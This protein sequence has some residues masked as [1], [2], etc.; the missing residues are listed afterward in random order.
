[1]LLKLHSFKHSELLVKT[2]NFT[3]MADPTES[4]GLSNMQKMIQGIP[5]NPYDPEI[6][7][8]RKRKYRLIREFNASS[9]EDPPNR[10]RILKE[11]LSPESS[12]KVFIE[13]NFRCDYG[14]N[15]TFGENSYM[16]FD[17]CILDCA[18]VKI[19]KNFLAGPGVHIYTGTHPTDPIERRTH[20]TTKPVTIGDDCWIGGLAVICPGVTLGNGVV[21]GAGSVVTKSF[22]DYVVIAGSP[23]KIIKQLDKPSDE[24]INSK[25][26]LTAYTQQDAK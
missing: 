19:G 16:N 3:D 12:N 2:N 18:P 7:A 10:S 20:E 4:A 1:M 23:A 14:F 6:V 17:C 25:P 5:Y 13:P 15:L 8:A 22:P 9:D 11:L 21:V 26:E 24:A